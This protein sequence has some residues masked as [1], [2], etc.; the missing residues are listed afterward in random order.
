M[1]DSSCPAPA[2][3]NRRAGHDLRQGRPMAVV[4]ESVSP[5]HAG[6]PQTDMSAREVLA[7]IVGAAGRGRGALGVADALLSQWCDIDALSTASVEDLMSIPGIGKATA[8]RLVAAFQLARYAEPDPRRIT[9]HTP[10]DIARAARR[11]L[12]FRDREFLLLLVANGALRVV[13]AEFVSMGS[14]DMTPFLV[15]E[16]LGSVLR[17]RGRAFAVAHNHPGG[18][19]NPSAADCEATRRLAVAAETLGVSFLGHVVV[20]GRRWRRVD[21]LSSVQWHRRMGLAGAAS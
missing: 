6:V 9:L 4:P 20:A 17:R 5:S 1:V 19:P 11:L 2:Q 16:I 21:P 8:A 18:D 14:A 13:H 7:A 15:P 12:L 3:T 10:E